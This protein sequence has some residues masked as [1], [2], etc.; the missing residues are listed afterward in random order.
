MQNVVVVGGGAAGWLTAL[1]LSSRDPARTITVID[2]TA[3]GSIGVGESVTGVVLNLVDD[4]RYELSIRDFFRHTDATLK[5][6]IWFKD[7]QRVGVDYLAPIDNPITYFPRQYPE[8]LEEFYAITAADRVQLGKAQI[9][10]HLMRANRTDYVR[11]EGVTTGQ[12]SN[13]SC[14]LDAVLLADWLRRSCKHRRNIVHIDDAVAS[15]VQEPESGIVTQIVTESGQVIAGDFFVD[16]SGFRRRLFN[17]AYR[18]KWIDYSQHIKVDSAIFCPVPYQADQELPVYTT[19]TALPH[20][21]MWEVPTQSRLGTGYLYSS[22]YV[23]DEEALRQMRSTGVE[24]GDSPRI[25]RFQPGRFASHWQGNVCAI[26]LAGGFI[27][28]LEATTIHGQ[29]AQIQLL[30]DLFLPFYTHRAAATLAAKYNSLVNAMYDDYVDFVSFHYHAGRDDTE[31]WRDYQQRGSRTSP[32]QPRLAMW[33]HTRPQ[34]EDF[35]P[36]YTTRTSMT[37]SM[38]VW[39]PMLC[40]LGY[41]KS[42][43]AQRLVQTSSRIDLA[44]ANLAQYLQARAMFNQHGVSHREA[45]EFLRGD[46]P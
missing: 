4:P 1:V 43:H 21:W 35:A 46:G 16:C 3:L 11:R 20:G 27:E 19:A 14:H 34:P 31:F 45:L 44:R 24:P 25:I 8:G 6:G 9:Y 26:G 23:S 38:V 2:P 28:A 41:L 7:W 5:L 10:A 37:S 30:A 29:N 12:Y 40:A 42:S 39:M 18:P 17:E 22:R 32:H 13:A 36:A 33:Q 15:F